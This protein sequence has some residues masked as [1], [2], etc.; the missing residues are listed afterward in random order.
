MLRRLLFALL[1]LAAAPALAQSQPASPQLRSGAERVVALL[2]GEAQPA[3]LFNAAFRAQVPDAQIHSVV[4]QF[5][6]QYGAVQRLEGIDPASAEAGTIHVRFARALVHMQLT[7]EPPAPTLLAISSSLVPAS[8]ASKICA[9][10]SLRA[11]C[12]PRLKS[13]VSSARSVWLSSTRYRTFIRASSTLE[14]RTNS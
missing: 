14:A 8:A 7:V 2:K 5:T 9:R 11:G 13:A 10:L 6:A 3:D 4:Q 12:L 1:L